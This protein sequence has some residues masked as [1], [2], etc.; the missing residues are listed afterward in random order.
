MELRLS[1]ALG[2]SPDSWLTMQDNC[3]LSQAKKQVKLGK[4]H[5]LKLDAA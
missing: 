2:R 1:K 5:R 3:D 4:V